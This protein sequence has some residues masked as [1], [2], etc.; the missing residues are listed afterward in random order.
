VN[1]TGG[2]FD[3]PDNDGI[4]GLLALTDASSN[5]ANL[6]WRQR[7]FGERT[8]RS[9]RLSTKAD[10]KSYPAEREIVFQ[11]TEFGIGESKYVIVCETTRHKERK[12]GSV[13]A[14]MRMMG[15]L[16]EDLADEKRKKNRVRV[17]F[18]ASFDPEL[19]ANEVAIAS[20]DALSAFGG[21]DRVLNFL[22][23]LREFF[24]SEVSMLIQRFR[25]IAASG[26]GEM[27]WEEVERSKNELQL[28]TNVQ[29]PSFGHGIVQ[30]FDM[31]G[32]VKVVFDSGEAR[33][34]TPEEKD[35]L[36]VAV[37]IGTRVSHPTRGT[38]TVKQFD[39]KGRVHVKFDNGEYHRY[40]Q[41]AWK[42]KMH[43]Y[44]LM[45]IG[46]A[47]G[48]VK[49][50]WRP[51]EGVREGMGR[52]RFAV[53]VSTAEVLEYILDYKED[54]KSGNV[55]ERRVLEKISDS[56]RVIYEHRNMP[57]PLT[58]RD[59]VFT[60]IWREVAP[61]TFVVVT[62]SVERADVP[63]K[64]GCV[65]GK[66]YMS[67]WLIE[68][69]Y[70]SEEAYDGDDHIAKI[71]FQL[72]MDPR[73]FVAPDAVAA[74]RQAQLLGTLTDVRAFFWKNSHAKKDAK[75]A[76]VGRK[77]NRRSSFIPT[78]GSEVAGG[79]ENLSNRISRRV[80][81]SKTGALD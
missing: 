81:G 56:Q 72:C 3:T 80:L 48:T 36:R 64:P 41:P 78:G 68:P 14:T 31:K 52:V 45:G 11:R 67:G 69:L 17:T 33:D 18:V 55:L 4:D 50:S 62:E 66:M 39:E 60:E 74:V 49:L 15:V 77:S 73:G 75:I 58:P 63:E 6:T 76:S 22:D 16:V 24:S 27:A 38:G 28:G 29:H 61:H 1:T 54:A 26:I 25:N 8:G 30:S 37:Q 79:S 43:T 57:A 59:F 9:Q 51:F 7:L 10:Q 53:G 2:E 20:E 35:D 21:K 32:R 46:G 42:K 70:L 65:R 44:K 13:R 47:L 5:A 19:T 40:K 71:T 12:Q 34:F 23:S